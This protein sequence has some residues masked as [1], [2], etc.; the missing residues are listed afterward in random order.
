MEGDEE[1]D[2][3]EQEGMPFPR[4]FGRLVGDKSCKGARLDAVDVLREEPQSRLENHRA[5]DGKDAKGP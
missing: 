1:K 2:D 4:P 3:V 5:K